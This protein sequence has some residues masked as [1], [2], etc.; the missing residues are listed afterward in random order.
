MHAT[1]A[2]FTSGVPT[3]P[4]AYSRKFAGFFRN[5][6]YNVLVDLTST[7]TRPAVDATLDFV[8]KA[9]SLAPQVAAGNHLAQQR[10]TVFTDR[11][12]SILSTPPDDRRAQ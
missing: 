7:P 11:L 4:V 9:D 10:L 6:D 8:R 3:I 12:S 5:L 2:S 1:I